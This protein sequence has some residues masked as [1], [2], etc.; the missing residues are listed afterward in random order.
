[1]TQRL[2]YDAG[3]SNATLAPDW[4]LTEAIHNNIQHL[5]IPPTYQHVLGHQ[6]NSTTYTKLSLTAQLNV[7]ADEA[8]GAFHWSHA[9][10]LQ[11]TVPLL[12]STRVHFNIGH[13]TITG[14]YKH[15]I[16]KAASQNDFFS[17]CR[18]IHNWDLAT[19]HAI[20]L[21]LFRTAVR[22]SCHRHKFLFKFVHEVLPTQEHK[23][24]WG[25][26]THD[27]PSCHDIDTQ[28]H[29][30][31]CP[32][33]PV[34]AWHKSFLCHLRAYLESFH[35]HFEVMVVLL[36]A[37]DAWLDGE[38]IDPCGYPKSCRPA[39]VAQNRIGWHAF[40]QG[41]WATEWSLLQDAHLARNHTRTHTCTG[42]TWATPTIATIWDHL[43]TA[44]TLHNDTV[45]VRDTNFED[46]EIKKRAHFRIIR[47]HQRKNETMAIHHDYFLDNLATTLSTTTLNFQRNWLNLYESAILESIKMAHAISL[48]GAH[49]LSNYFVVTRPGVRPKPQ[50]D[51]RLRTRHKSASRRKRQVNHTSSSRRISSYFEHRIS[52]TPPL[53]RHSSTQL[54][55]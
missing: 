12:P 2:Q 55:R 20:N 15:H 5:S 8:A 27:C 6:D 32:S 54:P 7:D 39:I 33:P 35:T 48:R 9:P 44:W 29:F 3:F 13:N 25:S 47:L 10:T 16:R 43:H 52:R 22:N 34:A 4:D 19:Y 1:M 23:S 46:A 37:I 38:A 24:K 50:F 40:L 53:N 28:V 26:A 30:L 11:E 41:Y 21:A 18:A 17:K 49:P 45:H 14:H 31:R 36:D 51:K 42:Q